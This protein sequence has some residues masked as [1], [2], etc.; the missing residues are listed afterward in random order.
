[1]EGSTKGFAR[2]ASTAGDTGGGPAFRRSGARNESPWR[3]LRCIEPT[4][5]AGFHGGVEACRGDTSSY[6]TPDANV[7]FDWRLVAKRRGLESLRLEPFQ[8]DLASGRASTGEE[9]R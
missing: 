2:A 5:Q 1:M 7:T 4:P 6:T 8:D 3:S 9:L